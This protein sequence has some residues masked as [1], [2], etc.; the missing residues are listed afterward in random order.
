[1]KRGGWIMLLGLIACAPVAL[2]PTSNDA[3]LPVARPHTPHPSGTVGPDNAVPADGSAPVGPL[4]VLA[5]GVVYD[6]NGQPILTGASVRIH[7][8]EHQSPF[9]RSS[10]VAQGRYA[11]IGVPM[12]ATLTFSVLRGGVVFISRKVAP[13]RTG[14]HDAVVNFGGP[15]TDEDASGPGFAVP[16]VAPSPSPRF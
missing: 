5:R 16:L 9:E 2:T 10:D 1:M 15:A 12:H 8:E 6:T 4:T 14:A 11:A 13:I 3:P 7:S